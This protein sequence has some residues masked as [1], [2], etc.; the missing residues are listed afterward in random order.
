MKFILDIVQ[1]YKFLL[2]L[3][4]SVPLAVV[5][6]ILTPRVEKRLSHYNSKLQRE[7]TIKIK[8]E[9]EKVREMVENRQSLIEYLLLYLIKS[10]TIGFIVIFWVVLFYSI[11]IMNTW[12]DFF[13]NLLILISSIIIIN[14]GVETIDIY[15]KVKNFENYQNMVSQ[16]LRE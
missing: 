9:L 11:P 16:V 4:L 2:G 13:A 7:R 10:I 3:F 8:Q 12:G 14:L 5:A 1:D 15:K 6:N